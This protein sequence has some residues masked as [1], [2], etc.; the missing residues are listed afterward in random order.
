MS[1]TSNDDRDATGRVTRAEE[2][3]EKHEDIYRQWAEE[4]SRRGRLARTILRVGGDENVDGGNDDA[5]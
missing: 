4:D 5:E 3:Y 1:A 2:A